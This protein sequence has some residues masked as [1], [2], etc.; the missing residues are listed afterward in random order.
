MS[1]AVSVA[2]WAVRVAGIACLIVAAC[3]AAWLALDR[4]LR[5]CLFLR[6]ASGQWHRV[7]EMLNSME[8]QHDTPRSVCPACGNQ[9]GVVDDCARC[10]GAGSVSDSGRRL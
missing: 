4:A 2:V 1:D 9:T 8:R 3:A 5:L 6:D 7:M 10:G